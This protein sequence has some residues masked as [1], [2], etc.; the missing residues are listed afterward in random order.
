MQD[1]P[2]QFCPRRIELAER[3]F[4]LAESHRD[5]AL[6]TRRKPEC[7][8][9]L[10]RTAAPDVVRGETAGTDFR[11]AVDEKADLH[12]VNI[13]NDLKPQQGKRM[14]PPFNRTGIARVDADLSRSAMQKVAG[15]VL[16][17]NLGRHEA[18]GEGGRQR[19]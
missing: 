6:P 17:V 1:W 19:E 13:R 4:D 15:K 5:A 16:S 9:V 12:P 7:L 3:A 18:R 2:R 8:K 10:N 14:Q 11:R